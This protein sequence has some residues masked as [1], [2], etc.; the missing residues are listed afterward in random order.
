[1]TRNG[2]SR[3]RR[4]LLGTLGSGFLGATAGCLDFGFLGSDESPQRFDADELESVLSTDVPDVVRPAPVQP[5]EKAVEDALDR[6]EELI[7]AVPAPLSA[8]DVPNEAVRKEI[9]RIH[10]TARSR[11]EAVAE[12]PDRFRT[13]RRSIRARESAGEAAVAFEAVE[14]DRS[15]ADVEAAREEVR[16]RLEERRAAVDHVGDDRQRTL[17]LEYRLERELS[18]AERWLD[19]WTDRDT[20]TALVVGELGGVVERARAAASFAAELERRHEERLENERSFA[21]SF[22]TALDRSLDSIDAA[23][24]PDESTDLVDADVSDT[25]GEKVALE[26]A[27]PFVNAAERTIDAASNGEAA[28]ALRNALAFERNRRAY[29]TIRDRIEDGAHRSLE[30]IEDVREVR[31]SALETAAELPFEPDE[32]SL[33]SDFLGKGYERIEQIDSQI[34]DLIDWNRKME[35]ESEYAA[36][37]VV[38]AQLEAI[39]DAVSVFEERLEGRG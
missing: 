16:T 19:E 7:D 33:G 31:E 28:T 2:T 23:D 15:R 26:G 14:G 20:S 30:T 18:L 13:L 17:L 36:Y 1:M 9:D 4:T 21:D 32:P 5:S 39:P 6:L 11:R 34:R 10:E 37:V 27:I 38:G 25:I 22:E 24:I 8:D 12:S 3:K 35:L 29:E